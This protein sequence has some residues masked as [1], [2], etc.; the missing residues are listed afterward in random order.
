MLPEVML[1]VHSWGGVRTPAPG[2]LSCV[3]VIWF[4]NLSEPLF[5]HLSTD[6]C[7]VKFQ[8]QKNSR[9]SDVGCPHGSSIAAGVQACLPSFLTKV[10]G[11]FVLKQGLAI[12]FCLAQ[13]LQQPLR[14]LPPRC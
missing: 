12:Q 14:Y 5:N 8:E 11:C 3:V 1:A 10:W 4:L 2:L 6:S 7:F 13:N 9:E